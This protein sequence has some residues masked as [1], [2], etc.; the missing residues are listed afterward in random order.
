MPTRLIFIFITLL[1][2]TAYAS[3]HETKR[4]NRTDVSI[5]L[6]SVASAAPTIVGNIELPLLA[7]PK[8]PQVTATIAAI[9]DSTKNKTILSY[10]GNQRHP[11]A[12][13]TKL[14]TA[15]IAKEATLQEQFVTITPE[16]VWNEGPAGNFSPGEIFDRNDLIVA[17]LT[18]S[19]N[20]AAAAIA[21]SIG[22]DFVSRMQKKALLLQMYDTTFADATGLSSLNQS[23]AQDLKKLLLYIHERHPE[24]LAITRKKIAT[25]INRTN[26]APRELHNIN[27]FAGDEYFIGGKTGYTTEANGN[28]ISLFEVNKHEITIVVLGSDDRFGDTQQLYDW[29]KKVLE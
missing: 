2:L 14:M 13:I 4:E 20:D 12:S 28:L 17:A 3:L 18:V 9:F 19:A 29:V 5:S 25:I 11:I 1:G 26:N 10:R 23:T 16:D 24:L 15:V 22:D 7:S 6:T 27:K 8:T 21:R